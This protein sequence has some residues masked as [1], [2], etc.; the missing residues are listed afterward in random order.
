MYVC[1][2]VCVCVCVCVCVYKGHRKLLKGAGLGSKCHVD[3]T[4]GE[5]TLGF[6]GYKVWFSQMSTPVDKGLPQMCCSETIGASCCRDC[7]GQGEKS[8]ECIPLLVVEK[9]RT[10]FMH[11]AKELQPQFPGGR[12][13]AIL[14]WGS[15]HRND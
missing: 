5:K 2:S 8:C 4:R 11:G 12:L 6:C 10:G 3:Q 15:I 9:Q 13:L 14:F 7:G 1:V